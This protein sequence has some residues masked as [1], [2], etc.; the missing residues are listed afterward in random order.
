[1]GQIQENDVVLFHICQLH[2]RLSKLT[3][4]RS[5]HW[6]AILVAGFGAGKRPLSRRLAE[7]RNRHYNAMPSDN[8]H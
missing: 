2:L 8:G 5:V 1:M 6:L 3:H 7:C 4:Y